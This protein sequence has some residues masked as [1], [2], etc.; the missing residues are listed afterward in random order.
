MTRFWNWQDS[1]IPFAAP[2]IAPV[3]MTSRGTTEDL[4]PGQLGAPVVSIVNPTP[5]PDPTGLASILQAIQNGNM[6]RDMTGLAATMGLAQS[7]INAASQGATA[8]GAQAGANAA[9]AA[10]LFSDLARTAA[11]IVSMGLG[12][13]VGGAAGGLLGAAGGSTGGGNI[14]NAGA[15]LNQG[16]SMT[17]RGVGGSSPSGTIGGNGGSSSS[18]GGFNGGGSGGGGGFPNGGNG[19]I[20]DSGM[21][22]TSGSEPI[23]YEAQAFNRTLWGSTGE[24]QSETLRSLIQPISTGQ[25]EGDVE[26]GAA[27]SGQSKV[28]P[29]VSAPTKVIFPPVEHLPSPS[30]HPALMATCPANGY[31]GDPPTR[32]QSTKGTVLPATEAMHR[33]ND[34]IKAIASAKSTRPLSAANLQHWLDGTGNELIMSSSPFKKV[35]SEVP[36]FLHG[37]ARSVFENGCKARLKDAS[38]PQGTLRP[39]TLTPGT[40]GPIRFLQ[41]RDGVRPSATATALSQDLATALG[42]FNVHCVI[43]AQATFI[44]TEGGFLGIGSD[45]VFEVE[46]L[47]W[48]VQI[49]DVYD[50]NAGA[51][52]PFP[53]S[54]ADLATLPLPP[55]AITIRSVG[56]GM[57]MA[58]IKDS[59][60]RDLEVSG[61]G[62]AYLIRTDAFE[63]PTSAMG[64]FTIKT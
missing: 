45:E 5:L 12:G 34:I 17:E 60:F 46:I 41:F 4:K 62:R 50:W 27:P 10:Q 15:L 43:W 23:N 18:G 32:N 24:S 30:Q 52:T 6:F 58:L 21:M 55:G 51:A 49:Y 29:P 64:K 25:A 2:E 35:D 37:K 8:A 9:T 22:L 44:K 59:Y 36:S 61:I 42:A 3:D 38:H 47:R 53:V 63:A 14:S 19:S 33:Q 28:L 11:S 31:F 39:S 13:A 48:C 20:D 56:A 57:N 7:G 54:D 16:R 26:I 40:K 1:P